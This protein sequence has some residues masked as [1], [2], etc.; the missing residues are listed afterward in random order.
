MKI[1]EQ[2]GVNMSVREVKFKKLNSLVLH[3]C[4][5]TR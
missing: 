3:T 5:Q 1:F 2:W 4:D